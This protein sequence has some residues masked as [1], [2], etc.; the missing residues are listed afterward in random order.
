MIRCKKC[1]IERE[2]NF[3]IK[4]K[5]NGKIYI[6]NPCKVCRGIETRLPKVG[7]LLT[8]KT[9]GIEREKKYFIKIFN[10]DKIYTTTKKCKVCRGIKI[11]ERNELLYKSNDILS[12]DCLDFLEHIK[13]IRG[14]VDMYDSFRMAHY[15]IE[16]FGYIEMDFDSVEDELFYMLRELLKVKKIML[17]DEYR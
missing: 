6:T 15:F 14:W 12:N 3:F 7:N 1:D 13:I 17:Q 10:N 11:N 2:S 16:T 4:K 9:C 8:C 5:L